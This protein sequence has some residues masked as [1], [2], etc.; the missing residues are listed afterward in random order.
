MSLPAPER[1]DREHHEMPLAQLFVDHRGAPRQELTVGER[2]RQEQIGSVGGKLHHNARARLGAWL[3]TRPFG[4][5]ALGF[6]TDAADLGR[7]RPFA[8]RRFGPRFGLERRDAQRCGVGSDDLPQSGVRALRHATARGVRW[9]AWSHAGVENRRL[10]EVD[11]QLGPVVAVRDRT[12]HVGNPRAQN[13]PPHEQLRRLFHGN[14]RGD[15][16][17]REDRRR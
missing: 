10:I 3:G 13:R 5:A 14:A 2:A 1:A 16:V 7:R 8:R 17:L 12:L 15:P 11:R 9:P 6:L 4:L